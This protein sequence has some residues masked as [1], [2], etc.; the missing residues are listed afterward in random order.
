MKLVNGF[1]KD[2][3]LQHMYQE[4]PG[5]YYNTHSRELLEN[6]V[7]YCIEQNNQNAVKLIDTLENLIPEV[8]HNEITRYFDN[9]PKE[10][11]TI[12]S[13]EELKEKIESFDWNI[14]DCSFGNGEDG[15]YIAQYSPAGE[16]FSFSICHNNDVP[17]AIREINEYA[18]NFD[19]DEHINMHIEARNNGLSGVPS[20]KELVEDADAIQKMLNDLANFCI[21][22]ELNLEEN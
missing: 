3:F 7:D 1:A 20:I 15:W 12:T 21:D 19:K 18:Y 22:L 6:L 17:E 5:A 4:F 16:D 9:K 11:I 14:S 2:E 8:T 13:L 10:K